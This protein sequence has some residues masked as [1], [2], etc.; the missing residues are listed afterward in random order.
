MFMISAVQ[1]GSSSEL[2]MVAVQHCQKVLEVYT[3]RNVKRAEDCWTTNLL[4]KKKL[5]GFEFCSAE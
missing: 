1:T 2:T 3:R 5:K 4:A